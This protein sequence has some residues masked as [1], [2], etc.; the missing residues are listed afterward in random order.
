ML[1]SKNER[2]FLKLAEENPAL[3]DMV[4]KF[5]LTL[6]DGTQLPDV[7]ALV[8]IHFS[9]FWKEGDNTKN[10]TPRKEINCSDLVDIIQSKW[11]KELPKIERPY[12]TPYGT[13]TKRNN[14]GLK[15]F[16]SQLIAL[17]YDKVSA[18]DLQYLKL[19]WKGQSNTILSLVSPSGNGLKVILRAKHNFTPET[20]YTGLKE[21]INLF[22]ISG[23]EP[24][25]MQFV[26][27]QP[28]FI[29]YSP[30]PYFNPTAK[31]KEYPFKEVTIQEVEP[32]QIEP[33]K[34][35]SL[36][37]VNTFFKNRVEMLC[38]NLESY[39][40][41]NGTHT[42]LYSIIKRIYPYIN[43][44]TALT[45]KEITARLESILFKRYGNH[46]RKKELHR[47][48][49]AGRYPEKSLIDLINETSR[50]QL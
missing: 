38:S 30:D 24:D 48:I 5:G 11:L 32:A 14:E 37:R 10:T 20:L 18:D 45:E 29:P 33:I 23:I 21:N 36:D 39:P 16:N 13:F 43:Q 4:N 49:E 1:L 41:G 26:L 9:L 22:T 50:V 2:D 17:D 31:L 27:S 6:Q 28:M 42:Y 7:S 44:Q 40:R 34:T 15:H 8:N 3:I 19:F 12:I 46:S 25:P 47:T 35:G